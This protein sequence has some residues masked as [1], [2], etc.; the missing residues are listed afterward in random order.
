MKGL[1]LFFALIG[2]HANAQ[3]TSTTTTNSSTLKMN[4]AVGNKKFA[5][6]RE[7]TDSKIKAEGGSLSQY[8]VKFNL[9]YYGP[10]IG[11]IENSMQPNPD[12]S[13]GN[14]STAL[15]GSISGRYRLNNKSTLG[16]GTGLKV[17]APFHGAE[18]TDVNNPYLN[19]DR[20]D[21]SGNLQMRN[22]FGV[23]AITTPDYRGVGQY[24]TLSYDSSFVYN[25]GY[26]GFAVGIDFGP[27]V[28]LYERDYQASDKKASRYFIGAFPQVKYNMTDKLN[29]YT[30]L[31]FT[32]QNLRSVDNEFALQNQTLS[33]RLGLGYAVTKTIYFA[34]Y[35]NFYPDD[36]KT[37]STTFSFATIFSVL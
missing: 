7:I 34:P 18:Q 16:L 28:F 29:M 26:S 14:R 10:P 22:S 8:S 21:R 11:D 33:G 24:G 36:L 30:S 19:Y 37:E 2:A 25:L 1:I 5:E 4:E 32:Y 15:S 20:N 3:Q 31:A 23:S 35:L 12:G 27:S 9:S 17:L 6:D 13:I